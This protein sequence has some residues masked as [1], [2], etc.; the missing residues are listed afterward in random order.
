[1]MQ[2]PSVFEAL[3]DIRW[4]L[5][6][7]GYIVQHSEVAYGATVVSAHHSG[8]LPQIHLFITPTGMVFPAH[9]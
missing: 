8:N 9:Y 3:N 4:N 7:L 6:N 5:A 2:Y 1:M